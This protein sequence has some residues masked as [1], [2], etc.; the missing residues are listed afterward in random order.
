MARKKRRLEPVTVAA[1][2]TKEKVRYEDEFQHKV[3][4]KVEEFGKKFEG[5]GR[6]ILYALG[7]L[8]VLGVIV[9]FIYSWNS[10]SSATAQ[11]AL[12]K[13]I[14][15]A[16]APVADTPPPGFTGRTF[17]TEQE[18]AEAAIVEFQAVVDKHGGGAGE[19]AKYFIAV[20]RLA[21]DKAAGTAELEA[22]AKSN[23]EVGKMAKFA[24]AQAYANDNK[25]DQAAALYSELA[26]MADPIISKETINFELA[27]IY[28]K[29]NKN[30]EAS[31]LLFNIVKSA[32][33]AKDL[34]GNPVPLSATAEAAKEK[35][36]QIDPER[37]KQL[38]Q[39]A[40]SSAAESPF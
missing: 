16:Q 3:G 13:A 27:K 32:N 6:N 2:E 30:Q 12:G 7:A 14:D 4:S 10:R 8:I 9:W 15:T 19:K 35:L 5:Q 24:L 39:P 34:D 29:Q 31:E 23:D 1:T 37:A 26:G 40:S 33:E 11:A 25:F 36:T 20:S 22:L 38:P 17:K 28:E 21:I 18:R